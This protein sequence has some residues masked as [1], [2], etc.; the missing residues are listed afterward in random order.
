MSE[1][2]Q[3]SYRCLGIVS[4]PSAYEPFKGWH[5]EIPLYRFDSDGTDALDSFQAKRG[6]VLVGGGR[7][8]CAALRISIPEAFLAFTRDDWDE[9][10]KL[11]QLV[12]AYWSATEAFIFGD[13]FRRI[14]W[15][16]AEGPLEIWLCDH[17]M[18]FLAREYGDT[19][20]EFVGPLPIEQDG[21]ICRLPTEEELRILRPRGS[22]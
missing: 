20:G 8:E 22:Q 18:S 4:C 19:F 6:D 11:D 1:I 5:R 7:G 10:Q 16:L 13:G 17:I 12:C 21:S 14:G 9:W 3:Y 2:D 15:Q